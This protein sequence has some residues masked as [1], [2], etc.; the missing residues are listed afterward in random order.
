M[1]L[2]TG[3]EELLPPH[4]AYDNSSG[5]SK[6]T[7]FYSSA[8][9]LSPQEIILHYDKVAVHQ[10]IVYRVKIVSSGVLV[11]FI[12]NQLCAMLQVGKRGTFKLPDGKTPE[13]F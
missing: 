3:N 10:R 8:S 7:R 6:I 11:E 9:K 13:L 2:V 1:A 12:K 4:T 5:S